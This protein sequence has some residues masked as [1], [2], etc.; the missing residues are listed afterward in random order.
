ML[1]GT[2]AWAQGSSP[3]PGYEVLTN[4]TQQATFAAQHPPMRVLWPLQ[5]EATLMLPAE[6]NQCVA[7][8]EGTLTLTFLPLPDNHPELQRGQRVRL[9]GSGL[10]EDGQLQFQSSALVD[11]NG[12]HGLYEKSAAAFF[13]AGRHRFRLQYFNRGGAAALQV[14]VA[15]PGLP[16]Q[17]IPDALLQ[18][19]VP[20]AAGSP[21][22]WLPG[23]DYRYYAGQWEFMPD[24]SR[25]SPQ[26]TGTISNFNLAVMDQ[27]VPGGL[28]FSGALELPRTGYYVFSVASDDGAILYLD[29]PPPQVVGLNQT[30]P[31]PALPR[32]IAGQIL[33][34]AEPE[35]CAE[36]EGVV[37]FI[38]AEPD[39]ARF[40]LSS[41]SGH[42]SVQMSR[43]LQVDPRLLLGSRIR[44]AGVCRRTF[45]PEGFGIA[46]ELIPQGDAQIEVLAAP[47]NL[48][49]SLPLNSLAEVSRRFATNRAS[50]LVHT[51]GVVTAIGP[52]QYRLQEGAE[53]V[54]VRSFQEL[55]PPT[56]GW[57]EVLGQ[58]RRGPAG[59]EIDNGVFRKETGVAAGE[60]ADL[61]L[62]TTVE[63][64]KQMSR[65]EAQ[66]GYPVKVRGVITFVWPQAGFFLQ[67]A[68]WSI[69]VRM[70]P[71]AGN[72]TP[73]IGDYW[74]VEGVTF[75]DFAPD[76][77]ASKGVKLGPGTL[78]EPVHPDWGQLLDGSLDTQYVEVQGVVSAAEGN[79]LSLLTR[80][81]RIR[82]QLPEITAARLREYEGD[83][84]RVRGCVIPGRDINTQRVKLGEFEL[85]N[86][87]ITIDEQAPA[88][89]FAL[90]VKHVS[91]LLLFDVHASPIQRTKLQGQV[92][93]QRNGE[94][95]LL[96]GT[97]GLRIVTKTATELKPGD[98]VEAVGFTDLSGPA[99]VLRD[100]EIR[101]T[102][103]TALPAPVPVAGDNV[104]SGWLDST[105]VRMEG[106]LAAQRLS[107]GDQILELHGGL[108]TWL[109]RLRS[110]AGGLPPLALGSYLRLTG[111][112]SAGAGDRSAGREIGSF[113]LLLNSPRD[114]VVLR[115]PS[116]WTTAHALAVAGALTGT[117]LLAAVWIR[118][119]RRR[120]EQ[121]TAELQEE[122]EDHKRTELKLQ[123]NTIRLT[124][125]IEERRR[126]EQEVEHSHKQLLIT[127]RLAG[128]AEVATS[129]LH[130]VGNVMTSVNVLCSAIMDLVRRSK[131][132]SVTKL[133]GLLKEQEP[134]LG[135][136]MTE[137]E[138]G[139][140][141]PGYVARLSAHLVE[142]QA[143][144][145]E[146][147]DVLNQNI[148]HINE[149]VAM[150]QTYAKVSGVVETLPPAEVV[151]DALR[152]HGE[153]LK[154]HG[155]E[156]VREFQPVPRITID[157]HKVLQI[158]FN[159]LENAKYA[160]TRTPE[161]GKQV[162]VTIQPENSG[163][164]RIVVA[165]NGMGIAPENL[166]RIFGQGF[167]TRKDG[168]GFGLHSSVLAAQDMGGQL[169]A[170]SDGVGRGAVF[171]LELPVSQIPRE[172]STR[173]DGR[174][175]PN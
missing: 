84:I 160:C 22:H 124:R 163:T 122:I 147:V 78:P 140:A 85:R 135:R 30:T 165:D 3:W 148:Q 62:L 143:E 113:E 34:G 58:A 173:T 16:R 138:R 120:V 1:G 51:R 81:G 37:S 90:P 118:V 75:A 150:Q 93:H 167:S 32:L 14:Y 63:Q 57:F 117:L 162:R 19:A 36:L 129:V 133:G 28:E 60:S 126:I 35:F 166:T 47:N 119:L 103:H 44:I 74:E 67:D 9:T 121:R 83:L 94:T 96:D 87:A 76:I 40:E 61:P 41:S 174:K 142:E 33:T 42:T 132:S 137:D 101:R 69:D 115:Q 159:L 66:R 39:A 86:A 130:N 128:M 104:L 26:A 70:Q 146:K 8:V 114:V 157:R 82:V 52:G 144:L 10:V 151:E 15:G 4:W 12:F 109:A 141:L 46:G 59:W 168:H 127:S 170:Q 154:R 110:D 65:A 161:P 80:G 43:E 50:L 106:T 91:D 24:F 155:I 53:D 164:I 92:L 23:V 71:A 56:N 77:N 88:D 20:V 175:Q 89:V 54:S 112:F 21:T 136:F 125:E 172:M 123:D 98:L 29:E 108:R 13:T 152:M 31:L 27:T 153:S 45:T 158:L 48:W 55:P 169:F 107:Q 6:A 100:A 134:D 11:N 102:G 73:Q 105:L 5:L 156:L 17:L 99:P 97:N 79:Y 139:K 64:V 111:V 72:A 145:L 116:W 95:F 68:T 131:V 25:L 38:H 149:I 2:L 171:T 49:E 7:Q 18:H